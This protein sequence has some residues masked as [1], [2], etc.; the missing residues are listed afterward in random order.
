ME[1]ELT[2]RIRSI[3]DKN[4]E[5]MA[6][7]ANENIDFYVSSERNPIYSP[8]L[9]RSRGHIVRDDYL[10]EEIDTQNGRPF[11]GS[12]VIYDDTKNYS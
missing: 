12:L 3:A 10:K 8:R 4:E 11:T 7:I 6:A 2:I 9:Q 5:I 1:D